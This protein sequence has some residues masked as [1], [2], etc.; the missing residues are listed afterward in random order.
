MIFKIPLFEIKQNNAN[1][2]KKM[3]EKDFLLNLNKS[4]TLITPALERMFDGEE[5]IT[6]SI[7]YRIRY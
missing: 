6:S 2:W 3:S 7:K 5:F 4:L 1:S